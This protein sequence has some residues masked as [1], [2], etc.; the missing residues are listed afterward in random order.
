M[1]LG[2]HIFFAGI[3]AAVFTGNPYFTLLA[4]IGS[5]IPDL[6]REYIFVSPRAFRDEQFHRALFHNLL[7]LSGLF[8]VNVWLALG[9]F[10]HS[11]LDSFTT[12]KDK[13]VEWLFPFSRLVKRGRYTLAA[14]SEEAGCKLE[15]VD[16]KPPDR[17]CFIN[18]DSPEMTRLS[19]PDLKE[20]RA[21]PWRRTYGPAANGQLFDRWLA[22]VS[23]SLLVV[24]ALVNPAFAEG[25]KNLIL[26]TGIIPPMVLLTGIVL[27]FVGG[28][29]K[30]NNWSRK[31]YLILFVVGGVFMVLSAVLSAGVVSGYVFPL[32]LTFVAA[33]F[34]VLFVE[35]LF[36][37]RLST[38]GGKKA[39]V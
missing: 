35:G 15:L 32:D 24:Y 20:T 28:A 18:E 34:V 9:A 39:L 19:D 7:F 16:Q 2:T 5:F 27:V 36:V 25:G 4:G 21:V 17:V 11:F 31:G 12:E 23:F 38:Y 22:L 10:L 13:G 30:K 37:W 14:R 6:D 33:G 26:S 1:N 8:F 3:V 29:L